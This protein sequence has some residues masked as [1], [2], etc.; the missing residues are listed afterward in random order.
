MIV[1][2]GVSV[3]TIATPFLSF[4]HTSLV[5]ALW[6]DI[7]ME[8]LSGFFSGF[9]SMPLWL[10]LGFVVSVLTLPLRACM[11]EGKIQTAF[12]SF[13]HRMCSVL[14]SSA[15]CDITLRVVAMI[16]VMLGAIFVTWNALKY[17]H[18]T[19]LLSSAKRLSRMRSRLLA[20]YAYFYR[21]KQLSTV[22]LLA[23]SSPLDEALGFLTG[24]WWFH[25]LNL[26][27]ARIITLSLVLSSL[28]GAAVLSYRLY[29]LEAVLRDK[30]ML[31]PLLKDWGGVLLVMSIMV[32]FIFVAYIIAAIG[33]AVSRTNI[34]LGLD[35]PDSNLLWTVNATRDCAALDNCKPRRYHLW[36]LLHGAKGWL[37]HSRLYSFPPAI[38]YI[39]GWMAAVASARGV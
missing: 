19:A 25:R 38:A 18:R 17:G 3:V 10:I 15:F 32:L 5:L 22:S 24:V 37:F 6:P 29:L 30:R 39:A 4:H 12:E 9:P 13:L 14:L 7:M 34:G 31:Y 28:V 23:V 33:R 2:H 36:P 20:R 1:N 21:P 8:S 26:W 27:L 35:S 11:N 16:A